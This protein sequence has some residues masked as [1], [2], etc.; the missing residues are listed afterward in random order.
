MA[1]RAGV[2]G[3]GVMGR[4]HARVLGSLEGVDL[5]GVFDPGQNVP[6]TVEGRPVFSDLDE[7]LALGLDY[8]VVAAPTIYHLD[9]GTR[10]AEL[11]IHALIEKPVAST[12]GDAETLRDL[13]AAKGLIG[14]V[15]HI[16]RFNPAV[17]A[18]RAKIEQGLIG[19]IYQVATRRQG[20]FPGRIADVGVV[21]DLASHDIDLTAWV[22]QQRYASV[23]A[24]IAHRSGRDHEDMVL[25]I[26]TLEDGTV[27]SHQ[28]NWLTPFKERTTLITGV[29]G[30]LM[31]DTLTADLTHYVN[32]VENE[33][34]PSIA[35]F[36]GVAEGDVTRFALNKKEPLRSEHE[37]FRDA[38]LNGNVEGIV[39]LEEGAEVVRI[40]EELVGDGLQH[41][42]ERR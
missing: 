21:K 19:E 4:N 41:Q 12:T 8:A 2:L 35:S 22:T 13:F 23:N 26:G 10:L 28:V 31:I 11:G 17:Q 5:V 39:T 16:E 37:A 15:G 42:I 32:G 20:P 6:E 30:A 18:A 38:V 33:A 40:A 27:V 36:R 3:L 14:G 1:L 24:R 9:L 29:S 25:A 7:L 34:W